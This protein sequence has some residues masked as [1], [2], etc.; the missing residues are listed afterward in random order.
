MNCPRCKVVVQLR[1]HDGV[2]INEC[3]SCTGMFLHRV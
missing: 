3:K 2:Q 1:D